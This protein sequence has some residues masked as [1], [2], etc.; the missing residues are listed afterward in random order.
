MN[1]KPG[2]QL[3]YSRVFFL[4]SEIDRLL[5]I[6][7][8]FSCLLVLARIA[9]TGRLTFAFLIWNLFLAFVPWSISQWL[10][11]KPKRTENKIKFIF[12]FLVWLAFV[13]NSFYILT[14]LYHLGDNYNDYRMP[15]WYDLAMILSFA[16]NGLMLGVMSVRQMEKIVQTRFFKKHELLFLYPVMWLNALGVYIGRYFRYN[17]WDV[18]TDPFQLIRGIVHIL[19]HPLAYRYASGMIFCFSILLTLFYLTLKKMSK[20]VR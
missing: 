11:L 14:D 8:F 4:R 7:M 10:M 12:C 13:P 9:Y 17:S 19:L 18:L 15:D 20:A 5:T 6:S 3:Y 1:K 2:F 16:W